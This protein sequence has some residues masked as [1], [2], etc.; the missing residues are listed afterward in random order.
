MQTTKET[1][2]LHSIM[3]FVHKGIS[4]ITNLVWD[5]LGAFILSLVSY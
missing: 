3:T 5:S 1:E 2:L 4:V